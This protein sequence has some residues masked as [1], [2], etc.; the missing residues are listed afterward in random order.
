M[1]YKIEGMAK[2]VRIISGDTAKK[3]RVLLN[4]MIALAEASG[5]EEVILPSIEP[6]QVYVDKAGEEI[7][8]QMYVFPDKKGRSLC[9]R[10]EGTATVQMVADKHFKR[11]KN[12]RLWYFERCWRYERPQEGRY[13]EFFQFG[14]EVINPTTPT[15]RQELIDLAEKMVALQTTEYEVFSAVKRGLSY[16]MEDGFEISVPKLGAQKQVVGGGAYKQGIGF[17]IG[18][19]RLML[20]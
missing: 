8:G 13:R 20:C 11:R 2:G 3:R 6:S 9:L 4:Q 5:F 1:E 10:P 12:V 7:L 16:Y 14:V 15:V 19:D 17:A 18:F